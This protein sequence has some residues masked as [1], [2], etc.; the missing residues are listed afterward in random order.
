[1]MFVYFR[2]QRERERDEERG[3]KEQESEIGKARGAR[4]QARIN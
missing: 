1:M 4:E 3:G 2:G